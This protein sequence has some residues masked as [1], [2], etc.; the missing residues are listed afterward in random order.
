[1][2]SKEDEYVCDECNKIT[3]LITTQYIF[4]DNIDLLKIK[5]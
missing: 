2:L 3:I 4:L 1:M 5:V